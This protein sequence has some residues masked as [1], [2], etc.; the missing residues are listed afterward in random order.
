M[1]TVAQLKEKAARKYWDVL[2]ACIKGET[3]F[4]LSIPADKKLPAKFEDLRRLIGQLVEFSKEKTG[5]GYRLTF[6][7]RHTGKYGNQ[8]VPT[9]ISF[10]SPADFFKFTGR[11]GEAENILS[12]AEGIRT[13]FPP[14]RPWVEQNPRKIHRYLDLWDNIFKVLLYFRENPRPGMYIRELPIQVHTKFIQQQKGILRELLEILIPDHI[15]REGIHFEERFHLKSIEPLIRFRRLDNTMDSGIFTLS[16]DQALPAEAFSRLTP[17]CSRV[18]IT[19]NLMTYLTLPPLAHTMAIYGGGFKVEI[20][21]KAL[22]LKS[23]TIIYWGDID[24]HGFLILSLVRRYFPSAQS[25][26]MDEETFLRHKDLC[27]SGVGGGEG[28]GE[29]ENS[30]LNLTG[31]E[32]KLYRR[33]AAENLRL[34]QEHL[35]QEYIAGQFK[36]ISRMSEEQNKL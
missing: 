20:L 15:H 9:C 25:I 12:A 19:E 14:L 33:I 16:D 17:Q 32:L 3:P 24:V 11:T 10:D 31:A 2:S 7:Q 13:L 29:G 4:P 36:K 28:D 21:K 30:P 23:K 1:I 18:A 6:D 22:W 5:Y 34:E 26:M 8:S 35:P 27:G